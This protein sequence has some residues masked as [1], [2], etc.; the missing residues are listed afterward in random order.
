MPKI[1][2]TMGKQKKLIGFNI[3]IFRRL[4]MIIMMIELK[5]LVPVSL[6]IVFAPFRGFFLTL[7]YLIGTG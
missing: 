4:L 2:K 3:D 7:N 6:S 5:K 1:G